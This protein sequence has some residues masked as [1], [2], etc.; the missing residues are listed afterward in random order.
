MY[1]RRVFL[2]SCSH[3]FCQERTEDQKCTV[4]LRTN[5]VSFFYYFQVFFKQYFLFFFFLSQPLFWIISPVLIPLSPCFSLFLVC[6][7]IYIRLECL[8][9]L[10]LLHHPSVDFQQLPLLSPKY[11]PLASCTSPVV[12]REFPRVDS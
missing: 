5:F 4:M 2:Q 9:R 8:S 3:L 12:F 1:Y 10:Y 7:G 6:L 11:S